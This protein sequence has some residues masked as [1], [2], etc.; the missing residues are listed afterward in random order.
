MISLEQELRVIAL[1]TVLVVAPRLAHAQRDT[2]RIIVGAIT[3]S[4]GNPIPYATI[5][6]GKQRYALS[7]RLGQFSLKVTPI[8]TVKLDVRRIGF[9]PAHVEFGAGADTTVLVRLAGLALPLAAQHIEVA[10]V[11]TLE[12]RGFYARMADRQ[13]GINSGEFITPEEIEQRNPSRP[14]QLLE[15]HHGV[16]VRRVGRCFV[17]VQ[18]WVPRG[19]DGCYATIYLDG[20]RL[21]LLS[22]ATMYSRPVFLDDL[23]NPS[24][25][26]GIEIYARGVRAPPRYQSL[27]GNCAII[28]IWTR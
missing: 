13:L 22:D 12:S 8:E 16:L 14:T 24:T 3:D 18:C 26:A 6:A 7:D 5:L 28:L 1:A 25:I 11:K 17:L 23:I 4:G 9:I 15:S 20:V 19:P 27:N 21:N 10:R 2:V